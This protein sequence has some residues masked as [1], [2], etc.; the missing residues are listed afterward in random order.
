MIGLICLLCIFPFGSYWLVFRYTNEYFTEINTE[1]ILMYLAT[2]LYFTSLF[3]TIKTLITSRK[4]N[5]ITFKSSLRI[6]LVVIPLV[7]F[8][9]IISL[10]IFDK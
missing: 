6:F 9:S 7:L 3:Y 8:L 1:N 10:L 2:V 4:L 5:K